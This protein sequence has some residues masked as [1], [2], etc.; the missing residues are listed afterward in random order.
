[1][2]RAK[3]VQVLARDGPPINTAL[4]SGSLQCTA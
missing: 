1:M 3:L 2:S 4:L